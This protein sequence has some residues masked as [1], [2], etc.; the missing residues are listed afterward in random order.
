MPRSLPEIAVV[1]ILI[2]GGLVIL[3]SSPG[4]DDAGPVAGTLFRTLRPIQEAVVSARR[5]VEGTWENYIALTNV[6]EENRRL[7]DRISELRGERAALMTAVRENRRLKK[8]LDLK[9]TLEF[10]SLAAQVIGEDAMGFHRTLFINRGSADGLA[11]GVAVTVAE[12]VVGRLTAV[13]G[14]V[15]KVLLILDPDLSVDCRTART[16]DRG[17]LTG[18]PEGG[19]VLRYIPLESDIQEGDEVVTSGLNGIY[20]KGLS[21]GAVRRV[22]RDAQGLFLE[23]LVDPAVDFSEIEEVLV[24]PSKRGGFDIGLSPEAGR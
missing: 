17:V 4:G 16:R 11:E 2:G 7:K 10:P 3:L 12:G 14:S 20:P 19:C 22:R 9:E 1:L 24:L 18:F 21:V 5:S 8:L 15:S 23:A 13:G 6:R